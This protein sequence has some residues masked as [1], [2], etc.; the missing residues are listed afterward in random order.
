MKEEDSKVPSFCIII[1]EYCYLNHPVHPPLNLCFF[2]CNKGYE[3]EE[4]SRIKLQSSSCLEEKKTTSLG[5]G[6]R[7]LIGN[8]GYQIFLGEPSIY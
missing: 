6:I 4:H 5:T 2:H 7:I 8:G 1:L 3:T